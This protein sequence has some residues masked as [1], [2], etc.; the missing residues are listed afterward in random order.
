MTGPEQDTDSEG[1]ET[2]VRKPL[3]DDRLQQMR[4]E[5]G[6]ALAFVTLREFRVIARAVELEHRIA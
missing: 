1:G 4:Q 3:S 2:D 5:N 6:G